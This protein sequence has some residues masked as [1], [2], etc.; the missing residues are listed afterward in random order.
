MKKKNQLLK[1]VFMKKK[2]LLKS[3]LLAIGMFTVTFG[4]SQN[5]PTGIVSLWSLDDTSE[6]LFLDHVGNHNASSETQIS[7]AQGYVGAA[8]IFTGSNYMKTG[9]HADFDFAANSSFSVECWVKVSSLTEEWSQVFVGKKDAQA[10]GAYW[11]LGISN[12][13][14]NVIWEVQN[15]IGVYKS[16]MSP[17]ALSLDTW[18]H[19]VGVRDEATNSN[20]L[21]IDGVL[22]ASTI[23]DYAGS[24]NSDGDLMIGAF[25]DNNSIPSFFLDGTVDEVAVYKRALSLTDILEH[26]QEN[27]Y[28]L[29]YC[30]LY[31]PV[32]TSTP[33][34]TAVVGKPYLYTVQTK[35]MPTMAYT[36]LKGPQGMTID[37]ATG[38]ISW[39]PVSTEVDGSVEIRV[40]NNIAPAD[41]QKFRIF[42]AEAGTCPDNVLLL[43]KLNETSGPTYS[44]YYVDHNSTASVAPTPVAGIVNG[45]QSFGPTT[46][47]VVP[48]VANEFEWDFN[49]NFSIELWMKTSVEKTMV[50]IG[51]RRLTGDFPD[52]ARWWVGT[53]DNGYPT[54][55]LT[56]NADVPHVVEITEDVP[57][58]IAD[59]EWHHIVAVRTSSEMK[60][61]VDGLKVKQ[62]TASFDG[63]GADVPTPV[64]VGFWPPQHEGQSVA[65]E[66]HF[67][68]SLDEVAIFNAALTDAQVASFYHGGAPTGHCA[69]DNYAPVITSTPVTSATE[70]LAYNYTFMVEDVDASDVI[71]LSAPTKPDWMTFTYT[72]GQ[73]TAT[74]SG[75]PTNDQVGDNAVV[76]QVSDGTVTKNQSFTISVAN[77]NDSPAFTSTPVTAATE[78]LEYNYAVTVEDVDASDIITISA[79][80]KPEWLTL[81]YTAGQKTAT[82]SATPTND[83]VGNHAVVL[84]V[85]DGTVTTE[86]S[87]TI[88]VS[89]VNDSPEIT[90]TAVLTG[91]VGIVY[92][93]ILTAT[94]VDANT[95]ITLS[96]PIIPEWLSFDENSGILT[97]TPAQ[98]DIGNHAVQ[99]QVSDGIVTVNQIFTI[100]IEGP[101]GINDLESAGISLFPVPAKEYLMIN[102]SNLA[103]EVQLDIINATGSV[104]KKSVVPA[105]QRSYKIDLNGIESG[106]YY[107]HIKN[108]TLNN[109]GRFVVTK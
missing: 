40:N 35:G 71:V 23:Y 19:I 63:F 6:D 66:Y 68:G 21:Y 91:Q 100:N 53:D 42:V 2:I 73:K 3:V 37:G 30:D 48:D 36:L 76:L 75:T 1:S 16:I 51:R 13:N 79:P 78:D 106:L 95:T 27:S 108:N 103:E 29:N 101:N 38:A 62:V 97:G 49:D 15:S 14:G 102:F 83:E 105:G 82:L 81:T 12:S 56:D 94:D 65:E 32:I 25:P 92:S 88:V 69:I 87:F 98:G 107:I 31:S 93:Y 90:S 89:N 39:T 4:F 17:T 18:H 46:G 86:Q 45:A 96:A 77:V 74:L 52:K 80:T 7:S 22:A 55:S 70:D 54:F 24:F 72:A 34:N 9:D 60:L 99:L 64:G 61:F 28:G 84:Q 41:T 11:Y 26:L 44:D 58:S 5:C 67:V 104:V 57:E 43:L 20:Y 8:K 85:T 109:I 33:A 59:G 47:I 10:T 50:M